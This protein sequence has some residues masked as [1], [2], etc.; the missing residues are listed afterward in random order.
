MKN[1]SDKQYLELI[2]SR[3]LSELNDLKRTIESASDEIEMPLESMKSIIQGETDF[4]EMIEFLF[5]L[6]RS[7]PIDVSEILMSKNDC[8]NGVLVMRANESKKSSRIFA[9][10][11]RDKKLSPYYEY[12][13]TAMSNG[14]KLRPE[15]IEQLRVVDDCD[16]NNPDVIY[17]NGHLMHQITFFIGPVNFYYEIAGVKYCD[18]MNTGDSNY[19]TP[20]IKHSFTSRNANEQALIIA[21]TFGGEVR[22]AQKEIYNLGLERLKKF[23]LPIHDRNNAIQKLIQQ[24]LDNESMTIDILKEKIS[25]GEIKLELNSIL[26]ANHDLTNH[27]IKNLS[28]LLNIEP[29][30]LMIPKYSSEEDVII[31]RNNKN[32]SYYYPSKKKEFYKIYPLA[33]SSRMPNGKSFNIEVLS[34]N[35][36]KDDLWECSLHQYLYNFGNHPVKIIW[37]HGN[38]QISSSIESGDSC[39][40]QPGIRHCFI[41]IS[42]ARGRLVNIRIAGEITL[43]VQR[44]LSALTQL[45]RVALETKP[46]FDPK[47]K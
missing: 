32:D 47:P 6:E 28:N 26:D 7:Y 24:Y 40:I 42:S 38:K 46:W 45:E 8:P 3:I 19:I 31:T 43:S 34:S 27:E 9:R 12:R 13:D 15:W 11:N 2:G 39:Y 23:Q 14:S 29:Y 36:N 18:E 10:A 20:F 4:K 33:R 44:E 22:S 5:K 35:Y 21:V 41:N 30:D 25:M 1:N 16:P 37:Q 17:N